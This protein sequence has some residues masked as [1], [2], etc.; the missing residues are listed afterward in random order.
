MRRVVPLVLLLALVAC[1]RAEIAPRAAPPK[2]RVAMSFT[3]TRQLI[4]MAR[5]SD[6]ESAVTPEQPKN[7]GRSGRSSRAKA[8][9]PA[10]T[11][12]WTSAVKQ[13]PDRLAAQLQADL[14]E[15]RIAIPVTDVQSADLVL[16][17]EFRPSDAGI[18]VAWRLEQ[19]GTSTLVL[20]GVAVD[21]WFAGSVTT[22]ADRM[23]ERLVQA[24]VDAYASSAAPPQPSAP[25][26]VGPPSSRTDGSTSWAV[27][28]G[29]EKYREALPAATHAENDARTFA[30]YAQKTLGIAP[31]R[32]RLLTGERAGR[33]DL[34]SAFEEWLPRNVRD[35]AGTV[36]VFFSG[37]G[38][39]DPET[40][41]TFL[42]PWD[43]DPA[44][45]KTRGLSV[46]ALYGELA[47]LPAHRVVVL[48]DACFSGG[49]DRS[50]LAEGTRPLVPVRTA[51]PESAQVVAFSASGA[52]ETTGAARGKPHGLFSAHVFAALSGE[53]DADSDGDVTLAELVAHVTGRV[54]SEA[55]L[56]NREQ[57]PVVNVPDGLDPASVRL[58]VG[59]ER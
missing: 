49:G 34:A 20:A 52:K 42:V 11:M 13:L 54:A 40:G 33:A 56:D 24:P 57:T 27:V 44:Y 43:A 2:T 12:S 59:V 9:A 3:T 39:P 58:V 14:L 10:S 28:V 35:G 41:E 29:I 16:T 48:L 18:E 26:R 32:I 7:A 30:E 6:A 53:A 23:L 37:H 45:L 46:K 36:Y 47:K 4:E 55:R 51:R 1:R 31:E 15:K 22:L 8:E 25:V 17:G 19:P 50:V 5:Q 38:A 21:H